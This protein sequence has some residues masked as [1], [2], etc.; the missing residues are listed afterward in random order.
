[1]NTVS[2]TNTAGIK[3]E[4]VTL[5]DQQR[6]I[7]TML[8]KMHKV[9]KFVEMIELLKGYPDII[10][11]IRGNNIELNEEDAEIYKLLLEL[12]PD[13]EMEVRQYF[14]GPSEID[15]PEESTIDTKF[16]DLSRITKND[17]ENMTHFNIENL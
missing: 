6:L 9:P 16:N 8:D 5:Q 3:Q 2:T 15:I 7:L 11:K 14:A 1:M 17:V 13:Q 4:I 12:P 10:S